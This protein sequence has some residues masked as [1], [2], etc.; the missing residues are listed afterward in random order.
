MDHVLFRQEIENRH[1]TV[2]KLFNTACKILKLRCRLPAS[3]VF[4]T[5]E[6]QDVDDSL[7]VERIMKQD[8]YNNI[9]NNVT[10]AVSIK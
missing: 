9:Y 2:V 8:H 1:V 7:S 10:Y 6:E 4:V 5:V 3:D